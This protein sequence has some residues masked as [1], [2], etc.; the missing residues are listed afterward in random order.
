MTVSG[1]IHI[2]RPRLQ[3]SRIDSFVSNREMIETS[4]L[5]RDTHLIRISS[6]SVKADRNAAAISTGSILDGESVRD[7]ATF[8]EKAE[9]RLDRNY[10]APFTKTETNRSRSD[11]FID[12]RD[13]FAR[14]DI[15]ATPGIPGFLQRCKIISSLSLSLYPFADR[16]IAGRFGVKRAPLSR[17][18]SHSSIARRMNPGKSI[19]IRVA[20]ARRSGQSGTCRGRIRI[21]AVIIEETSGE[22]SE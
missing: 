1:I 10:I 7:A 3:Q 20:A 17:G 8:P 11:R 12:H 5:A 9:C 4:I 19:S 13:H 16:A 18:G 22:T 6:A 21:F 14:Y 2:D 15:A